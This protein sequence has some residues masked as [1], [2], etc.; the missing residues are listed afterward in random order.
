MLKLL[1]CAALA[2]TLLAASACDDGDDDGDS[3]SPLAV[4][5]R[6]L[7]AADVQDYAVARE[8]TWDTAEG[9]RDDGLGTTTIEASPD[10][11]YRV[12]Q[13]AGFKAGAGRVFERNDATSP[14]DYVVVMVLQL[15][16]DAAARDVLDFSADDSERPCPETCAFQVAPTDFQEVPGARSVSRLATTESIAE[17]GTT[18][19]GPGEIRRIAFTDGPFF[20][21]IQTVNTPPS[22]GAVTMAET[23]AESLYGRV[24][25]APVPN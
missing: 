18:D 16:S 22:D 7:T 21:Y 23:L 24:K 3:P 19:M 12:V 14:A 20:Y 9:V 8:Y 10:D 13:D 25:D 11:A 1:A 5:D 15:G 6:L 2:A 17:T 4:A